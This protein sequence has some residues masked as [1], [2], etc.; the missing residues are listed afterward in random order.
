MATAQRPTDDPLSPRPSEPAADRALRP[1]SFAHYVG[2][3]AV[4]K[5]LQ[6]FIAAARQRNE[7]L[8]HMLFCGPP[9][10]GKTT[11]AN[12]IAGAMGGNL[13]LTSGPAV[14]RK[15]DLAGILTGLQEGD[16]LFIDEIHRLTPVV[17]E[18][19]YPAMEDFRFDIVIGDGPHA[20]TIPLQLPRFTLLGATTRTG[21]MTGPLRDRFGYVARL[22]FYTPEELATVVL[23][24]AERLRAPIAD[25]A[26]LE[27]AR[28]ARGTPRIA[29]RLLK[30]V[31][32][33]AIVEGA[34][35]ITVDLAAR[36]LGE[37]EVDAAGLDPMD[38]AYL[39]RLIQQFGGGP[40]GI[41]AIAAALSE[42]RDTLEDVTEPYLLQQ[43]YVA[44]TPRGRIAQ[45][46]AWH[47]LGLAMPERWPGE[48]LQGRL[49]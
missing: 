11:L 23:R 20:R 3:S 40:V 35:A 24:S 28:R 45:P 10:L 44:R 13:V 43:G 22:Q 46:K 48:E 2:Q 41:E 34:P 39:G 30:S 4:V 36:T 27:I 49:L 19:L 26:A 14:E 8:D 29:N 21:L 12:L 37:L 1:K 38:R 31:R 7:P 15:G 47:H 6:V 42:A 33:F 9:G 17:E 16:I 32:D 5:N 18:N 25:D